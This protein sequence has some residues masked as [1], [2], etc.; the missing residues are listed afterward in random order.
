MRRNPTFGSYHDLFGGKTAIHEPIESLTDEELRNLKRSNF[1]REELVRIKHDDIETFEEIAKNSQEE[2]EL[3][4]EKIKDS[5]ALAVQAEAIKQFT[6]RLPDAAEYIAYERHCAELESKLLDI[7]MWQFSVVP[8]NEKVKC[9]YDL[10]MDSLISVNVDLSDFMLSE[11]EIQDLDLS[12]SVDGFKVKGERV[13]IEFY[14][15]CKIVANIIEHATN[16]QISRYLSA[17]LS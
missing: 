1:T 15:K 7:K 12:I 10:E 5:M 16:L 4:I 11:E 3:A 9:D 13:D 14:P 8:E 6:K 17:C 2:R